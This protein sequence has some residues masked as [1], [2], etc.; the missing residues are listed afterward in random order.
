MERA[1][2]AEVK[3]ILSYAAQSLFE[4]TRETCQLSQERAIEITKPL[5]EKGAYYL[6]VKREGVVVGWILIGGNT[7]YFSGEEIGFIY[8]LYVFPEYRG[9]GLSR[10]LMKAGIDALQKQGYAEIRLNVFAGNFAKEM[11]QELGF[12]ERQVI[13]TL[14]QD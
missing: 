14:K 7:D 6:V 3:Q 11:Y 4:G 12:V 1:N 13:M 2:E 9:K 5:L 10:K 8:E